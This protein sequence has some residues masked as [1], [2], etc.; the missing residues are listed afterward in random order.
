MNIDVRKAMTQSDSPDAMRVTVNVWPND[1]PEL[2]AII[3]E[4]FPAWATLF[5]SKNSEYGSGSAF[6]LGQRG[7]FSDI[8]RKIIKLKRAMWDEDES[9]L[10]TEGVDEILMDMIGHCFLTLEM[11][12]RERGTK[13]TDSGLGPV[14]REAAKEFARSLGLYVLPDDEQVDGNSDGSDDIGWGEMDEEPDVKIEH[15][16]FVFRKGQMVHLK[17]HL[18]KGCAL[19]IDHF[20][21]DREDGLVVML[22][23]PN[24]DVGTW[25]HPAWLVPVG[26]KSEEEKFLERDLKDNKFKCMICGADLRNCGHH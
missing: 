23:E 5:A 12:S 15:G 24:A 19:R 2:R 20:D 8:Y 21:L 9:V 14:S 10:T 3:T 26:E 6:E 18:G 22:A 1:T 25:A 16:G 11:R 17:Q 7:Q 13:E 4:H